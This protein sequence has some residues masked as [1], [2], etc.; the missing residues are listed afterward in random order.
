MS[1][2]GPKIDDTKRHIVIIQTLLKLHVVNTQNSFVT[3]RERTKATFSK[4]TTPP[5]KFPAF[6][7]KNSYYDKTKKSVKEQTP[8]LYQ[9]QCIILKLDNYRFN[10]NKPSGHNQIWA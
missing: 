6:F 2:L 5:T 1:Q 3:H 7:K 9:K 10:Q 4:R 8:K